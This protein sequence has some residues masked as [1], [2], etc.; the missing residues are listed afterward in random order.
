MKKKKTVQPGCV[1]F[2]TT[3][4]PGGGGAQPGWELLAEKSVGRL[5]SP[6][7]E[8]GSKRPLFRGHGSQSPVKESKSHNLKAI[9]LPPKWPGGE[10]SH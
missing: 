3:R 2:I 7:G 4:A 6:R 9:R 8:G 5:D 1:N 10:P